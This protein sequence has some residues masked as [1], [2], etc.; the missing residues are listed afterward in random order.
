MLWMSL[1]LPSISR[2]SWHGA[3]GIFHSQLL[4]DD[5]DNLCLTSDK[6]IGKKNR[7]P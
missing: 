1:F 3:C 2:L 7:K 6:H 4:G 5:K